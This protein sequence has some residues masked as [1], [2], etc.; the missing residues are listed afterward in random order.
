MSLPLSPATDAS[1]DIWIK[2]VEG[3][4]LRNL[5]NTPDVMEKY[6]QFSPDGQYIAFTRYVQGRPSVF[7][8]SALGGT[9]EMIADASEVADWAPDGRSI[10]VVAGVPK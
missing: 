8:V 10:V 7:K 5:T 4:A 6:P 3:D 9:E 2:A 1:P